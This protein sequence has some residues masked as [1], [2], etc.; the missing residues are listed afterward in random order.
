MEPLSIALALA[1]FAP[2]VAGWIGGDDA[3][4]TVEQVI[5]V[6][7]Q[8]TGLADPESALRQIQNDPELT[9]RFQQAMNPVIIA[10]LQSDT[11]RL[12]A[13][14]TTMV[15]ESKSSDKFVRRW[16]PTFGY[17]IALTW[18]IQMTALGIVMVNTPADAPA[19]I[20]SMASLSFMW[21]IALSV[22]G[23]NVSK[24]SQDKALAAGHAPDK[25]IVRSLTDRWLDTSKGQ[26]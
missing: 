13:I 12:V 8:V 18:L 6:A 23:I 21:G 11:A 25:S 7:K 1:K 4:K 3:E 5:D 10:K 19:V 16:R 9:I 26:K 15:A 17:M 20:N 14:N 22:L 2:M 24:R